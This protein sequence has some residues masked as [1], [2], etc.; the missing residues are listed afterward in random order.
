MP[1]G[2]L[3]L[4]VVCVAVVYLSVVSSPV[5]SSPPLE[6]SYEEYGK[7]FI[8]AELKYRGKLVDLSGVPSAIEK[9][10]QGRYFIGACPLGRSVKQS[11]SPQGGGGVTD[12][13][14]RVQQ[15]AMNERHVPGIILYLRPDRLPSFTGL[16]DNYLLTVRGRCTGAQPDASARP[17]FV[18]VVEDCV[19]VESARKEPVKPPELTKEQR[20][21]QKKQAEELDK[22]SRSGRM[23]LPPDFPPGLYPPGQPPGK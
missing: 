14:F 6:L 16:D 11:G 1:L 9:D 13:Y 21:F 5:A 10:S 23:F 4:A 15:A 18:V 20:D 7:D 22:L 19:L 12:L 8:A 2:L 3:V 17:E